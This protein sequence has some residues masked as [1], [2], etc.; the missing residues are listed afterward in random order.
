MKYDYNRSVEPCRA[1]VLSRVLGKPPYSAGAK[2]VAD[3]RK[4]VKVIF[5]DLA[6]EGTGVSG[7]CNQ[8]GLAICSGHAL[9]LLS[10]HALAEWI[11]GE[12][13]CAWF[14]KGCG[15]ANEQPVNATHG[16]LNFLCLT[17][18][19]QAGIE[20]AIEAV[21][22]H[23][24]LISEVDPWGTGRAIACGARTFD[25]FREAKLSK[26]IPHADFGD[27]AAKAL[28]GDR[29]N[30]SKSPSTHD[31]VAVVQRDFPRI[32]S[33]A[34]AYQLPPLL[35]PMT[36]ETRTS[37]VVVTRCET[38]PKRQGR[39]GVVTP[40]WYSAHDGKAGN[41]VDLWGFEEAVPDGSVLS[42]V[43]TPQGIA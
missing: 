1:V 3:A 7:S 31:A 6:S 13:R 2:S 24:R 41:Y 21:G 10:D 40:V 33:L 16:A 38:A 37:G 22:R 14:R 30:L 18:A 8:F 15:V 42:S 29:L 11:A 23:F 20:G 12:L 17:Y 26:T 28:R 39:Y 34:T 36:I 4:W 27:L 35:Y 25:R 5:G 32:I 43:T 9:G 19:L